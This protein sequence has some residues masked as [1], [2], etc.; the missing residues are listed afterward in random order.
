MNRGGKK[1]DRDGIQRLD[2][3]SAGLMSSQREEHMQESIEVSGN[4]AGR[5]AGTHA[6]RQFTVAASVAMILGAATAWLPLNAAWAQS[7]QAATSYEGEPTTGALQEVVVTAERRETSIQKTAVAVEAVS[8]QALADAGVDDLN[9]IQKLAPDVQ[10]TRQYAGATVAIRGVYT[11]DNSPSAEGAVGVYFDNGFLSKGM[12]LE[13]FLFDVQR[14]EI[15]KGPQGTLFGADTNGGAINII[16][17]PAKL[18]SK[19]SGE[20]EVEGGSYDLVRTAGW[21]NL[22]ISDT[23]AMRAAFQTLSHEGYMYSGLDDEDLHSARLSLLWQPSDAER[24]TLVGDY[25]GSNSLDDEAAQNVIGVQKFPGAA[26]NIYVPPNPRDD[27]FYY[28]SVNSPGLFP[29]HRDSLMQGLT[30]QNDFDAGFATWTTVLAYR[31]FNITAIAP[32]NV[33]Q[34]PDEVAPNGISSPTT[35]YAY[36]PQYYQSYSVESRLASNSTMPLKWIGGIY[37]YQDHD[38]GTNI[39]YS[40]LT[41]TAQSSQIANP[42]ELARSGAVF[43][44]VTYTPEALAAL[45]LTAGWRG[46]VE[47]KTE[48]DL[49]TQFGPS[50]APLASVV[51]EASHTWRAGTYRGEL[52]YDLTADSL[53]YA[54]TATGFKAGG[55]GYGPGVNPAAGPIYA[56]EKIT[57]YEAGSKNRFLNQTLQINLE[58]WYY[59]YKDY[60]TNVV[61]FTPPP[62]MFAVVPTVESA[63][64]ATYRGATADIQWLPTQNDRFSVVFSRLY[65]R[66]GSYIHYA[67]AGFSL[68]PGADVTTQNWSGTPILNVPQYTGTVSYSHTWRGIVGGSLQAEVDSQ[69]RGSD[70]LDYEFAGGTATQLTDSAWAMFD[71]SL[72]YQPDGARWLVRAYAHNIANSLRPV[73]G[74]LGY[75]ITGSVAEAFFPPRI[76]GAM[77]SASF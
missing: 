74:S 55:Y 31:H 35:Q 5:E 71:L 3:Q 40:S 69:I 17:N 12:G 20:G 61:M 41:A 37:L 6:Q 9:A 10:V 1:M 53:L 19:I 28:G 14:V 4:I 30:A 72:Q 32:N 24:F 73:S 44:Q 47:H 25:S 70:V 57:A 64:E 51:P 2:Q 59:K 68:T 75:D 65:G 36:V 39:S 22:P 46:D 13:G 54:D 16:S 48:K 45:H 50:T 34:G 15:D 42:Y 49:F 60:L 58:A 67:G 43:G 52:S 8:Q 26:T 63:G 11:V 76:I 66:Y 38:A 18:D 77:V 27:T 21:V 7:A 33:T 29:W 56:P 62:E 23:L